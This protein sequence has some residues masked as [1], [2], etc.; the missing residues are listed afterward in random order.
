MSQLIN[1]LTL[2]IWRP[3]MKKVLSI[4]L[5]S[6]FVV[7]SF[8]CTTVDP[9]QSADSGAIATGVY[10]PPTGFGSHFSSWLSTNG[11]GSAFPN[12]GFGGSTVAPAPVKQVVIFLHGNGS[13]AQGNLSDADGWKNSYDHFRANGYKDGELYALNYPTENAAAY[14][15]H[16]STRINMVKNFINAVYAYTGK[17]V[18]VVAHSLGVTL[19]RKAMKDGNLYSKVRTF[20]ALCGANS[21]LLTCG[22]WLYGIY[23]C[24]ATATC[25]RSTGLCWYPYGT[26]D[27]TFIR[28]LKSS[29]YGDNQMSGKTTRTY[30]IKSMVDEIA[31]PYATADLAG[32]YKTQTYSVVP[33]GH[34]GTK[35]Y[36]ASVQRQMVEWTY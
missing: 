19:A 35:N 16:N 33:Y 2:K 9:G 34:F 31:T 25:S 13:K 14:N 17:Q 26:D 15:D 36:S 3:S 6:L 28:A 24:V 27:G 10:Y 30:V 21:G 22:Y 8:A 11:Y 20:V 23:Y 32:A 5:I 7:F 29:T 12:G 1:N 18:N 4:L